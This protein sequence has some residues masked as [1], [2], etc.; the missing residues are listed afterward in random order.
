MTRLMMGMTANLTPDEVV[1]VSLE[2]VD[3]IA[4]FAYKNTRLVQDVFEINGYTHVNRETLVVDPR[5]VVAIVSI[6]TPAG[7]TEAH[8]I[9]YT[10]NGK[11]CFITKIIY[12]ITR[13]D[14]ADAVG[15]DRQRVK[16][17]TPREELRYWLSKPLEKSYV[18]Y[19]DENLL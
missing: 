7:N 16:C 19:V 14:V 3:V 12:N 11:K 2:G 8:R 6:R 1:D 10:T 18:K 5:T 9:E 15:T 13:F 4:V 17:E